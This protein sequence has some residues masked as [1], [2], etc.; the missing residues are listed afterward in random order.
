MN[1]K[2]FLIVTILTFIIS[3]SKKES[4]EFY[5]IKGEIENFE[6]DIFLSPAIDTLY[7]SNNFREDTAKVVDGKFSFNLSKKF[8]MPLPFAIRSSNSIFTMFFLL[9]PQNQEILL[10]SI[11]FGK[12]PTI[13]GEY[14]LIYDQQNKIR[15][16]MKSSQEE[17]GA[18]M[19][20]IYGSNYSNDSILKLADIAQDKFKKSSFLT[21]SRFSKEYPDSYVSFWY[22]AQSQM[23]YGYDNEIEN[24]YQNL[25]LEIKNSDVAKL[26][27]QKMLMSK[28][29]QTGNPFPSQ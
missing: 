5:I 29:S 18:S 16:R 7:Y 14:Q 12:S 11:D 6:G 2:V 26:F 10:D 9:E 13:V 27:E 25:S 20:E 24:A 1:H 21:I 28:I 23:I 8:E 22:I 4:S 15:E 3:C 19:K 17:L